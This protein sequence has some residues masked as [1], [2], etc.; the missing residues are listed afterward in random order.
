M[1]GLVL[2]LAW[3]SVWVWVL[4]L[5]L[6]VVLVLV[7]VLVWALVLE[8]L[9]V[10]VLVLMLM[11]VLMSMLSFT[12]ARRLNPVPDPQTGFYA[13]H[14]GRVCVRWLLMASGN[15]FPVPPPP[16]FKMQHKRKIH[17]D[18]SAITFLA[19]VKFK[20]FDVAK[21]SECCRS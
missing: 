6:M 16:Y 1:S 21:R 12:F 3:V 4:V 11:A 20:G 9:L 19:G 18:L 5:R 17:P 15:P 10:L 2:V 13:Q 7:L 14:Y 8:P